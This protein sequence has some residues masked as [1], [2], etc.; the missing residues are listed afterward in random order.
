MNSNQYKAIFQ[1]NV[2]VTVHNL[3]RKRGC[4]FPQHIDPKHTS[5][6]KEWVEKMN[7]YVL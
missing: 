2:R 3:E 1:E 6:W 5:K 7:I 4:V